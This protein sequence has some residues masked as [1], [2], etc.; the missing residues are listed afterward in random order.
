[1]FEAIRKEATSPR[2]KEQCY[3]MILHTHSA[4]IL[5]THSC[6]VI[7][8]VQALAKVASS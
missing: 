5:H 8:A 7:L 6:I 2:K 3:T 4:M 1:M